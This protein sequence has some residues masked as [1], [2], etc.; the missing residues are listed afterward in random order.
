MTTSELASPEME[1]LMATLADT[2]AADAIEES[3]E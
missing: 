3:A 2:Y 1:A